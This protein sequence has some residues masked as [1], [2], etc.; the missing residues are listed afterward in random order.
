[1]MSLAAVRLGATVRSFDYD[2]NSVSATRKLKEM[3][4]KGDDNNWQV[5][6]GSILDDDYVSKLGKFDVVYSWGVLHHTGSMW[7][8]I[9]AACSLANENALV[10]LAIYNDC[11]ITSRFWYRVK[12]FYNR[13]VIARFLTSLV[14]VPYY[15][16]V[17]MLVDMMHLRSPFY[18][19]KRYDKIGFRGMSFYHDVIDWIGGYPYE[20]CTASEIFDRVKKKG[21]SLVSMRT[22]SSLGCN[23]IV[24]K[25]INADS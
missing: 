20:Y 25:K 21:F 4:Y 6:Q 16:I 18:S 7:K 5:E 17:S 2:Q 24:F 12:R 8:G 23:E 15:Y 22:T 13:G 3:F 19:I 1:I 11:G 14:F 9:D 10:Y